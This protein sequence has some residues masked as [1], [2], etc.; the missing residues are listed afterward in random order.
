MY[1]AIINENNNSSG[2]IWKLFK[3]IGISKQK[4]NAPNSTVKINGQ[5][6]EDHNI[7]ANAFNKFFVSVASDL[8]EHISKSN[9]EK[10]KT[11]CN[12]KIPVGTVFIIREVSKETVEKIKKTYRGVKSYRV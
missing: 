5:E 10:L 2:N 1:S 8:K 3:E 9:F 11:L 6:T 4:S 12:N 7:M